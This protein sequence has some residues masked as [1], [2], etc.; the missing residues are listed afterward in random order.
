MKINR[1]E[2]Y[3]KCYGHCGYCGCEI[4][5]KEMQV[6]HIVS[7]FHFKLKIQKKY[8]DKEM[9]DI[10]IFFQLVVSVTNGNHLTH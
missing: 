10:V 5:F 8:T 2:V 3:D 4:T 6:D 9:N 1:Q 7:Q